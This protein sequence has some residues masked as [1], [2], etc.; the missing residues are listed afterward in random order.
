M[1]GRVQIVGAVSALAL[2]ILCYLVFGAPLGGGG[3]DGSAYY[4]ST[5]VSAYRPG[6]INIA[7]VRIG[8]IIRQS[9]RRRKK[10]RTD[11]I[12]SFFSFFFL[13]HEE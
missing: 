10:R 6:R 12:Y 11:S 8:S 2:F 9:K 1:A 5:A 13:K 4:G 7:K 3:G